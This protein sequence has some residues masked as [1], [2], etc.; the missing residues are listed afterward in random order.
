MEV[1]ENYLVG[2]V[3][4]AFDDSMPAVAPRRPAHGATAPRRRAGRRD[5]ALGAALVGFPPLAVVC[6]FWLLAPWNLGA[7]LAIDLGAG[8]LAVA[9]LALPWTRLPAAALLVFPSIVGATLLAT[10]SLDRTLAASYVGFITLA[11]IFIG[12]T[13]SRL[14]PLLA[15]PIAI[16]LYWWCEIHVTPAIGVRLPMAALIWLLIGEL[17]A[18]RSARN[19]AQTDGLA[20]QVKCDALTALNSR[21]ELFREV[22]NATR[23]FDELEGGCFLFLLD[24]DGFKSVNDTFGHHVGDEVLIEMA[25]RVRDVIRANDVPARLGGDE[26]AILVRG[27][28]VAIATSMGQR[29]LAAAAAP[30]ELAISVR[31][32]H[33]QRGCGPGDRVDDRLRRH[34]QRGYRHV[35]GKVERKE[36]SGLFPGGF[37]AAHCQSGPAGDRAL[38]RPREQESELHWQPTAQYRDR[39]DRRHGGPGAVAPPRARTPAPG[40]VHQH[41]RGHRPDRAARQ[42]G[43]RPCLRAGKQVAAEQRGSSAHHFGQRIPAPDDRRQPLSGREERLGRVGIAP[44]GAG[45][46]N[47]RE[48]ADGELAVDPPATRRVEGARHPPGHRRLRHRVL[49]ARLP[50]VVPDRYRQNRPIVRGGTR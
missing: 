45:A 6:T 1:T 15:V 25:Q 50:T 20:T 26:F 8:I 43:A 37:A 49:V 34:P 5:A 40:R 2:A 42:V 11:F 13:Q 10:A 28:N 41:C 30:F 39:Q 19:R 16:P 14:V 38:Q 46:R 21:I 29:L 24:V 4:S 23:G 17:L 7:T 3:R 31:H 32:R 48:N 12:L 33:R 22:H 47:N 35:R 36:P 27:A 9:L 44:D 18:D